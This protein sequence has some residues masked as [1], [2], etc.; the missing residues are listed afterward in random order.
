MK[1]VTTLVSVCTYVEVKIPK[2][3]A[4]PI[5]SKIVNNLPLNFRATVG[6]IVNNIINNTVNKLK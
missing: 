6:D 2:N 1:N 3:V 4:A 5:F